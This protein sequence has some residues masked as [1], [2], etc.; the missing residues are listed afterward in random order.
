MEEKVEKMEVIQEDEKHIKEIM[1]RCLYVPLRLDQN[2]RELLRILESSLYISQY[3][4]KIDIY[5]SIWSKNDRIVDELKGK[6]A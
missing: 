1:Q 5:G 3:T 4:D 6:I 2:E